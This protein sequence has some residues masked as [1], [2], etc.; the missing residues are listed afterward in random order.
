MELT[1]T[2]TSSPKV[3]QDPMIASDLGHG[4]ANRGHQNEGSSLR[5]GKTKDG[6]GKRP[7]SRLEWRRGTD[8]RWRWRFGNGR[9]QP[10]GGRP[11]PRSCKPKGG[12]DETW[13]QWEVQQG[14]AG[15]QNTTTNFG[16][17]ATMV[18]WWIYVAMKGRTG[19]SSFL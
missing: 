12:G 5:G 6:D 17:T 19:C 8:R 15:D 4:D 3:A 9:R 16:L 11:S 10:R 2:M 7:A 1:S 14:L 18:P 13:R